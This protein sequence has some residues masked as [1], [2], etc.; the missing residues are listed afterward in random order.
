MP[1]PRLFRTP[2]A[3]ADL[4]AL[5]DYIAGDN[6]TAAD[7]VLDR[8]NECFTLLSKYPEMG[9]LQPRLADGS[10]R[11]FVHRN[12]VIYYRPIAD[13][14]VLVRVLHAAQDHESLL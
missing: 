12:Y 10:Y 13:G 5:W 6:P 7:R 3:I 2:G 9:E 1:S 4:D 14:I 8:L 11:R